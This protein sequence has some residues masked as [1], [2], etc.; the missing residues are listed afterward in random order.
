MLWKYSTTLNKS[1]SS[2]NSNSSTTRSPEIK[3]RENESQNISSDWIWYERNWAELSCTEMRWNERSH[4]VFVTLIL[5]EHWITRSLNVWWNLRKYHYFRSI[6]CACVIIIS[7]S[8]DFCALIFSFTSLNIGYIFLFLFCLLLLHLFVNSWAVVDLVLFFFIYSSVSHFLFLLSVHSFNSP[9]SFLCYVNLWILC[10]PVSYGRFERFIV[11]FLFLFSFLR[12]DECAA[13]VCQIVVHLLIF[14]VWEK[15]RIKKNNQLV[16]SFFV[17][18]NN[19]YGWQQLCSWSIY[20]Q[21]IKDVFH[22]DLKSFIWFWYNAADTPRFQHIFFHIS[23]H[24]HNICVDYFSC[25][26]VNVFYLS[27][28]FTIRIQWQLFKNVQI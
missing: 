12:I 19:L 20:E 11:F 10:S 17:R 22:T 14:F 13:N 27:N 2:N 21:V 18:C 26:M 1:S 6:R 16:V 24:I 3:I 15:K 4:F 5:R 7:R 9:H 25:M 28:I 8:F 23:V